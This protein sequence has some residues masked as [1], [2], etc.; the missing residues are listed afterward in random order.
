MQR[1]LLGDYVEVLAWAE[2]AGMV[3][4]LDGL[5]T[6]AGYSVVWP[7]PFVA[8]ARSRHAGSWN[9]SRWA[10][11]DVAVFSGPPGQAIVRL[12]RT[13]G[14]GPMAKVNL[15]DKAWDDLPGL[16]KLFVDGL[17]REGRLVSV[18][19]GHIPVTGRV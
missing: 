15:L 5:L 16:A 1:A 3:P 14:S 17:L 12:S 18:H 4:H 7:E 8:R 13:G 11:I 9:H 2:P 19:P 10:Q 6:W